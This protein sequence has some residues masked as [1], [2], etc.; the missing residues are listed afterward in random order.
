MQN[1]VLWLRAQ[2]IR[3]IRCFFWDRGFLEVET[4]LLIPAN[5]PE[6]HIEP[7]AALPWQLQTSPELCMKRLICRGHKRLF[8]ISHCWR[9]N[10]RGNRHLSEFTML[11]WYRADCDYTALMLDCE[12]LL[13]QIAASCLIDS[14]VYRHGATIIDPFSPWT[15]IS[16]QEAFLQFSNSLPF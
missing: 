6:E 8:Q 10:E 5:A 12:A 16:V 2:I 13:Q 3:A 7:I 9:N 15:K 4:P 11:E 14:P 1:D